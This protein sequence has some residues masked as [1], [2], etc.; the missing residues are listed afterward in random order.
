MLKSFFSTILAMF[1]FLLLETA[2]FSNLTYLP[3]IPDFL[4]II[5]LFVAL[6]NGSLLAESTGF[7]SGFLLDFLSASPLGLNALLRTILGFVFGLF[8]DVLNASSLLLQFA[9]GAIATIIKAIVVYIISF[10]FNGV[11]HYSL[12][13]QIFITEVLLNAIFTPLIFQFL[14]LFSEV[15]IVKPESR[16]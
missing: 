16:L 8:H 15:L 5:T 7:A 6:N 13:S 14:S 1:C 2:V 4:L 9:Y 11:V 3:A 10:F 12:F